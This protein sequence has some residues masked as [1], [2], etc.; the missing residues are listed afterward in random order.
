[1]GVDP[2]RFQATMRRFNEHAAEGEDPVEVAEAE[3]DTTDADSPETEA[4]FSSDGREGEI[5]S[6]AATEAQAPI[7]V[8]SDT[9]PEPVALVEEPYV[10]RPRRM[11]FRSA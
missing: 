8:A 11:V 6:P 10:P 5:G 2:E 4:A 7:A 1:M 3:D 9:T